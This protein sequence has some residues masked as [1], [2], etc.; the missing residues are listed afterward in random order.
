[1]SALETLDIDCRPTRPDLRW[2]SLA[3][4]LLCFVSLGVFAYA[5]QLIHGDVISGLRTI[6]EGG[7][8]WGLYIVFDITFVGLAFGGIVFMSIVRLFRLHLM[9]PF[10]RM[11]QIMA[12]VSLGMAGLCVIADL[13]RPLHGLLNFPRYAR[14]M[15]PFFGTFS[16]VTCTGSVATFIYLWLDSR[17]DAARCAAQGGPL[18]FVY[19]AW[20]AGWSDTPAERKRHR[21]TSYWL[22]LALL[23]FMVIGASTLGFVFG[24]QSA[25]PG[26]F[27]TLQ[28]PGFVVLALISSTGILSLMAAAARLKSGLEETIRPEVFRWL[29]TVMWILTAMYL[30]IVAIEEL[31]AG[32]A[33][34]E[35][36]TRVANAT[37]AGVYG[38]PFWIAMMFFT[39][40][41]VLLF[42][43][44]LRR[45]NSI[46]LTVFCALLLNVA[47][48]LKRLLI[49]VP[50]QT[51]GLLLPYARG[52][53]TP[54][55]IEL[56]VVGGL[57]A[58]GVLA[59]LIFARIFPVVPLSVISD[60]QH[61]R[62]EEA[63]QKQRAPRLIVTGA[64]LLIG[65]ALALT[66]FALS[67]RLGT[68]RWQDPIVPLSPII[69]ITGLAMLFSA[70]VVYE[71][72]PDSKPRAPVSSR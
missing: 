42:A 46:A 45:T 48:I 29:G 61:A 67:A 44:T 68:D 20:A 43:Q 32:Y 24:I 8:A 15:S 6:G 70:A 31:T 59:C 21:Q 5:Q 14:T 56:A 22:A 50:S 69:F 33:A 35:A 52:H 41:A 12:L 38:T 60:D 72:L 37:V 28:A 65:G 18:Q 62:D 1:M 63:R 47:A 51:D 64:T 3:V 57:M 40:P 19:R 66:G 36:E 4:L 13:G 49:V 71:I 17:A 23:P 34:S 25:R 54:S 58:L 27:G 11:A 39:L 7:A 16:L 10:M 53:Y 55:W 2:W 9:R 30:Y 26:W